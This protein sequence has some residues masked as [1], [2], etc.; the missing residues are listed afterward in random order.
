MKISRS[1]SA[2]AACLVA[3]F[4]LPAL[5]DNV[6]TLGTNAY[7]SDGAQALFAGD[8]ETGIEL[9][10]EGLKEPVAR[11]QRSAALSNLCAGY[12]GAKRYLEAEVACTEA[13][14]IRTSNWRALNNRAIAHLGLGDYS[15]ARRDVEQGLALRPGSRQL[16][17]VRE[18]LEARV[19][20]M[21][22]DNE[23]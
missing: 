7:L 9:T 17:E 8:Y 5:A 13:L 11:G 15:A 19:P 2:L 22:A 3:G 12:V 18:M 21:L 16:L 1:V 10:L 6:S 20:V 23:Q 4:T 14:A